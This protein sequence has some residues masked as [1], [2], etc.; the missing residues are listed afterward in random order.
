MNGVCSVGC[1]VWLSS[2]V[3]RVAF[4]CA[5]SKI[6]PRELDFKALVRFEDWRVHVVFLHFFPLD[7]NFT[8][9]KLRQFWLDSKRKR[10]GRRCVWYH[11]CIFFSKACLNLSRMRDTCKLN[12]I[13]YFLI[14][15]SWIHT[16]CLV[17][18]TLIATNIWV[19]ASFNNC[20][21]I[22][23]LFYTFHNKLIAF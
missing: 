16:F 11:I 19:L 1:N 3:S 23:H 2:Y 18:I 6:I 15:L 14:N 21:M 7:L 22:A 17:G 10:V 4:W 8:H 12:V 5:L 13:S 9:W 20:T